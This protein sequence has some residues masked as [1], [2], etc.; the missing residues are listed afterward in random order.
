MKEA[1]SHPPESGVDHRHWSYAKA[2]CSEHPLGV[3]SS[4]MVENTSLRKASTQKAGSHTRDA[5][6]TYRE[7]TALSHRLVPP[8]LK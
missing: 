6:M 3:F 4:A 5:C 1:S 7:Y 2:V 8:K